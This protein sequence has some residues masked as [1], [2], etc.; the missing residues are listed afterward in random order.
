MIAVE[1]TKER[2]S[3]LTKDSMSKTKFHVTFGSREVGII[4]KQPIIIKP[5]L[6][7]LVTV[8]MRRFLGKK[9]PLKTHRNK[10]Y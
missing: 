5:Q 4:Q 6:T 3:L 9:S 1:P 7:A 2:K 10:M 8:Y